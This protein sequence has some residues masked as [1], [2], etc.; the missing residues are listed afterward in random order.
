MATRRAKGIVISRI[1]YS[2]TSQI[3][4]F[5]TN[6][7]G[8]L[9][10]IAKG[11]KRPKNRLDGTLDLLAHCE[12]LFIEKPNT[13]LH[14]LTYCEVLETFPELRGDP[15]KGEVAFAVAALLDRFV[16]PGERGG[17]SYVLAVESLRAV[18]S[19]REKP[20]RQLAAF[21]AGLLRIHGLLPVT[22]HCVQCRRSISGGAVVAFSGKLG[23]MVCRGC[24]PADH[25]VF[26]TT[27]GAL[28]LLSALARPERFPL[29]RIRISEAG[30]QGL[31]KLLTYY[32]SFVLGELPVT[33]ARFSV[34]GIG[35]DAENRIRN[36]IDLRLAKGKCGKK[37]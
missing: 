36:P 1:D 23:G 9:K 34:P 16:Q 6:E 22:G 10:V 33:L 28:A 15:A 32:I 26:R 20:F 14:I 19:A 18:S 11:I 29:S 37:K 12:F 25:A 17:E 13:D 4:S 24:I 2:E 7:Y 5:V 31:W 21:I 8:K 35:S 30:L 27:K 3:V